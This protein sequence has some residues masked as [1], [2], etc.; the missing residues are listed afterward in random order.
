MG[1]YINFRTGLF[2]YNCSKF[3]SMAFKIAQ[4]IKNFILAQQ[5]KKGKSIGD[6]KENGV[7]R[8]GIDNTNSNFGLTEDSNTCKILFNLLTKNKT[9]TN[10]TQ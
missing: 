4:I 9:L 1:A 2:I 8:K 5:K 3:L 10:E 6:N 7:P